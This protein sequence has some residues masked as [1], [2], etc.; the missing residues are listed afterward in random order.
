MTV[1]EIRAFFE[2][3]KGIDTENMTNKVLD[4]APGSPLTSLSGD[5]RGYIIIPKK[6]I[7]VYTDLQVIARNIFNSSQEAKIELKI[8]VLNGTGKQGVA[9]QISQLLKTYGY[10]VTKI[11]NATVA[12]TPQ[13]I[14]YNCAGSNGEDTVKNLLGILNATSKTKSSCGSG[15]IQIIVGESSL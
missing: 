3:I 15:N 4:T 1:T 2:E 10:S 7:G 5:E 11:G 14:I 12:T 9:T 6:G 13:T 8:E